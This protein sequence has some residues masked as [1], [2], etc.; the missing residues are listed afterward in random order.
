MSMRKRK[1]VQEMLRSQRLATKRV[2]EKAR[3][4]LAGLVRSLAPS[5]PRSLALAAAATAATC[6]YGAIWPDQF[7]GHTRTASGAVQIGKDRPVWDEYGLEDAE[8]ATY[9]L[10]AH[11]FTGT[12]WR[13]K[14]PTGAL[15]VFQW[16]QPEGARPSNLAGHAVETADSVMLGYGNYVLRFDGY[17]PSAEE[18]HSLPL[19]RFDQ[20]ALPAFVSYLPKEQLVVQSERYV[21]GP[22]S[23]EKFEPRIPPSTAAFHLGTEAQLA[24]Y[25]AAGGELELALFSYPT[26]DL[27]RDRK[28]EFDRLPGALVKRTGPMLAVVFAPK[29]ADAA[30]RLLARINY[31]PT[32]TM[33]ERV[34]TRKDNIGNLILTIF[35]LTGLL[36]VFAFVAGLAFGA[37]RV[38]GRKFGIAGAQEPMIT[39]HLGDR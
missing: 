12:A 11:K 39:L 2:S 29:D 30:E 31:Q 23:L 37:F 6:A 15:A 4:R 3:E 38:V 32:L 10:G 36:L 5:L 16:Q 9:T 1:E 14:D 13:L 17:K 26:P 35:G 27:A 8:Q 19:A 24:R 20:S 18:I 33:N 28:T 25:Q 34:P 22:A 7:A 21:T